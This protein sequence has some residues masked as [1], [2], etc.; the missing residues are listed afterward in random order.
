[1]ADPW[2]S[3]DKCKNLYLQRARDNVHI[4]IAVDRWWE[5]LGEQFYYHAETGVR[6]FITGAGAVLFANV[7]PFIATVVP[8]TVTR[9]IRMHLSS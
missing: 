7:D 6:A 8:V 1:M 4:V 5:H 3:T 2:G 9:R